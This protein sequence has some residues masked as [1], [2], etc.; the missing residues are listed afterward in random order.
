MTD[1][2]SLAHE[3]LESH[4]LKAIKLYQNKVD[5]SVITKSIVVTRHAV[6]GWLRQW[7]ANGVRGLRA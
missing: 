7:R 4:R 5:I 2:R 6:Y 1:G 3:V